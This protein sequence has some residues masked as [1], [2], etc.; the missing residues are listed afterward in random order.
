MQL[1]IGAGD[2]ACALNPQGLFRAA[3]GAPLWNR[4]CPQCSQGVTMSGKF[5]LRTARSLI[6]RKRPYF[7]HLALTHLCNLRCHFCHIPEEKIPEQDTEGMKRIIDRLDDL[8]V[9]VLSISGGGEPLLRRD[10][11]ELLNYASA[12]GMFTKITSNGTMPIAKYQQLLASRVD[13]IGISLDG[14]HDDKLP[15]AHEGPKILGCIRYLNDHLPEGKLL[16]LNITI[17]HENREQVPE[18]VEYCSQAFPRAR[19]WLN[20]VVVGQGKLRVGSESKIDPSIMREVQSPTLLTPEFYR[21]ACEEYAR[22]ETYNWGCRAGE[23]FFDIK[24]NGDF[25]ICQD[26]PAQEALNI[27]DP[28]FKAKYRRADF[29]QRRAC[30]GCTY[31]C[32]YMVQKGLEPAHWPAIGVMWWLQKTQP[33]DGCRETARKHGW[34]AGLAHYCVSR[35]GTRRR[36]GRHVGPVATLPGGEAVQ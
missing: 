23:F 17:S 34:V 7:A 27:L 20:P 12:K 21:Q 35:L 24:P 29:S 32:Y 4:N 3:E 16:T 26:H 11:A 22:S 8:G 9:A 6:W 2:N 30:S 15:F 28:E 36:S 33:G 1:V 25:W 18:I 31:S 13:E 10:F 14:V 19:L 5:L